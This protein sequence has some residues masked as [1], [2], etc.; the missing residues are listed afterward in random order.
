MYLIIVG[1]GEYGM[2]M[3][4]TISLGVRL[5]EGLIFD[6]V[7]DGRCMM[8]AFEGLG[9]VCYILDYNEECMVGG[10]RT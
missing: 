6:S 8:R 2:Y 4:D 10:G 5:W 7:H 3:L 1:S 9:K